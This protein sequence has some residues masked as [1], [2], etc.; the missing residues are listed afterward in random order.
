MRQLIVGMMIGGL[1][2][3]AFGQTPPAK[4]KLPEGKGQQETA[5][6]CTACHTI[7]NV[8]TQRHDRA[9]WQKLVDDMAARGADGTDE[10]LALIVDYLTKNFTPKP[11]S[12][13]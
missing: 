11:S 4:N 2:L 12:Q 3:C 5:R 1:A 7:D 13:N 6:I 10:Q 8:V 9:G